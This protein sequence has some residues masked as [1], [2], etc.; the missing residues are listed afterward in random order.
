MTHPEELLAPYVDG[1]AS[2][3]ER[4]VV[5]AH[6]ASCARCRAEI[7]AS[8][9]ARSELKRLPLVDAPPGLAPDARG[10]A[11]GVPTGGAP[12][13]YRW[14]GAAAVAAM[15]ALLLALVLPRIGGSPSGGE[16]A[17][18]GDGAKT[19]AQTPVKIELQPT[20]DYQG[21]ALKGTLTGMVEGLRSQA[22]NVDMGPASAEGAPQ[23][24]APKQASAARACIKTAFKE[25]HGTLIRLISAR[26]AGTPAYIGIYKE[27]P[28][29][30]Q[31]VDALVARV[32]AA[33]TCTILSLAG[34][35]LHP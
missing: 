18:S 31:P 11:M 22:P 34:A 9:A 10:P 12:V 27:G 28:G 25:V 7:A 17:L 5:A 26:F 35:L 4:A 6:V 15:I 21:D 29:T 24:G 23:T 8:A 13:W 32:A 30:G 2:V 33:D 19:G 3:E 16:R 14:G 1:T 20:Q